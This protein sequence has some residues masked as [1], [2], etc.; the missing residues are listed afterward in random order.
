MGKELYWANA[1]TGGGE[2]ALDAIDGDDLQDK[3]A[4]IVI[5]PTKFSVHTLKATS[6]AAENSPNVIAPDINAGDKRWHMVYMADAIIS[7]PASGEHQVRQI[8]RL[9]TGH[10]KYIY[11]HDAES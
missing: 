4:A 2:G 8:R 5:T 10:V 9:S 7:N 3:E 11:D 6:G 1:L